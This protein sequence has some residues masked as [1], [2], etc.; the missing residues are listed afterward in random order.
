MKAKKKLYPIIRGGEIGITRAMIWIYWSFTNYK[1]IPDYDSFMQ[2]VDIGIVCPMHEDI[3]VAKIKSIIKYSEKYYLI[4]SDE[5]PYRIYL[6]DKRSLYQIYFILAMQ[7]KEEN[8][9]D[10][11]E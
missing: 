8:N 4:D 11:K 3:E 5:P 10:I 6:T 7:R 2:I 9:D 1:S